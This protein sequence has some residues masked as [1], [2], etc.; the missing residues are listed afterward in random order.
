MP[1]SIKIPRLNSCASL[2]ASRILQKLGG[3]NEVLALRCPLGIGLENH[4]DAWAGRHLDK[5]E[6]MCA[7]LGADDGHGD[8]CPIEVRLSSVLC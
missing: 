1:D 7:G 6:A 4:A 5:L 3:E 8:G 2:S